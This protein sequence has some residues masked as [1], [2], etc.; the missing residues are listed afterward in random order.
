[1]ILLQLGYSVYRMDFMTQI[2]SSLL[3]KFLI[4]VK[5]LNIT[6]DIQNIELDFAAP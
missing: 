6:A 4:T 1:M 5:I 2:N 3:Q